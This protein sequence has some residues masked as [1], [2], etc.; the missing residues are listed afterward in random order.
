MNEDETCNFRWKKLSN[1]EPSLWNFRSSG[2]CCWI[3]SQSLDVWLDSVNLLDAKKFS[4]CSGYHNLDCQD[5]LQAKS[6]LHL[7]AWYLGEWNSW[8]HW[9]FGF[10]VAI[11]WKFKCVC[12]QSVCNWVDSPPVLS[13]K[14]AVLEFQFRKKESLFRKYFILKR[15]FTILFW[16]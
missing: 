16:L 15:L 10:P 14:I 2:I 8:T 12:N 9:E 11:W 3:Q 1:V 4:W 13:N 7:A 5:S 6:P